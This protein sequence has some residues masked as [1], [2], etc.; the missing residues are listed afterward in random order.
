MKVPYG[1]S[2]FEMMS[3]ENYYYVDKTPFLEQLENLSTKYHTF[4]R[5]RR[6]G[7][8]LWVSVLQYYYGYEYRHRFQELFGRFYIGQ[9]PTPRAN[10][11]L[12]LSFE[13]SRIDTATPES[14]YKGFLT[15]VKTAA[16][17]FVKNYKKFLGTTSIKEINKIDSPEG[18]L[19]YILDRKSVV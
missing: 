8:S 1:I 17:R 4:L 12:V 5:P 14:T 18:I 9:N 11:F 2:N 10:S 16:R 6:F 13:F 15:N 7:K 3:L 19:K